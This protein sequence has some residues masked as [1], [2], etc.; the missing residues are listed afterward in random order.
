A[1]LAGCDRV[2]HTAAIVSD[3]GPMADFVRV[4][5]EGTRNVLDAA[6]AAGAA[7]VVCLA[8]VAV[9][10]YRFEGEM[11][12][13]A[14]PRPCGMPYIDTKGAAEVLALARGATVVRPGDVY[15]PGS[16]PWTIRPLEAMRSGAFRLPGRG[17]GLMTPVYVDDLVDAI[18]RALFHPAAAGRAYTVWDGEA[19]SARDFFSHH[20]R[21]L[22][23]DAPPSLPRPLVAGAALT[24]EAVA[25]VRRRPP[26]VSRAALTYISR[27]G[28]YPNTRARE[29]LGWQPEVGLAEGMRRTE[30]WARGAGLLDG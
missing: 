8:S 20:A 18:V 24:L 29:E 4:N 3:W 5:V 17:D 25:R 2:V 13:D 1:A 23:R 21:M 10:G 15:G 30:A 28:T 16:V 11:P 9:W 12:E 27:R 22:G 6:A 19:V 26:S 7:R 14:P